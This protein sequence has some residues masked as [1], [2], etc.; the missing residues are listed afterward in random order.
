MSIERLKSFVKVHLPKPLLLWIEKWRYAKAIAKS[1]DAGCEI[2]MMMCLIEK[3]DTVVDAG[4]NMG[5]YTK[6]LARAVGGSGRVVAV[7]PVPW[8]FSLLE[9]VVQKLG[10]KNV[11]CIQCAVS[12]GDG[13]AVIS[14]PF[15]E[16]GQLDYYRAGIALTNSGKRLPVTIH[17]ETRTIDGLLS[18]WSAS[19]TFIKCD[20]EGHE[21]HVL[22]GA[23]TTIKHSEPALLVEVWGRPDGDPYATETFDLMSG[24]GY[25]A[26]VCS[27]GRMTLCD[28]GHRS[29]TDNYF[30]LK[31][32]HLKILKARGV[33]LSPDG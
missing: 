13:S 29:P 26:Y 23:L 21:C 6:W 15:D 4:A 33:T 3:G 17:V 30:F 18:M 14:I 9:Y 5:L 10:W 19:P 31:E 24:L 12:D 27:R 8:T 32:K 16:L 28:P 2:E 22:R 1:C 20:V 25:Q 7:E 11:I